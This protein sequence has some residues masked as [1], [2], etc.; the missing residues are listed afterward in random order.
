V[1]RGVRSS[2]GSSVVTVPKVRWLKQTIAPPTNPQNGCEKS[3]EYYQLRA[4]ALAGKYPSL[5]S[6][7]G[8]AAARSVIGYLPLLSLY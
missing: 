6:P 5:T 1:D 8:K 4:A 3:M 7:P 2:D